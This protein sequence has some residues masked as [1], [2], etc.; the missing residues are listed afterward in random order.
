MYRLL[1]VCPL[2]RDMSG[3]TA[4]S[5]STYAVIPHKTMKR[6]AI[7]H[8]SKQ[9]WLLI[10]NQKNIFTLVI[11]KYQSEHLMR[12]EALLKEAL[13][14]NDCS[15]AAYRQNKINKFQFGTASAAWASSVQDL[16]VGY[17]GNNYDF[18]NLKH[19]PT[20]KDTR[21]LKEYNRQKQ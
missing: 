16:P 2:D 19:R 21:I 3:N 6:T 18:T 12:A 9:D 14:K 20:Y 4:N 11:F 7:S 5:P 1:S 15:H 8:N 13:L 17:H 10:L